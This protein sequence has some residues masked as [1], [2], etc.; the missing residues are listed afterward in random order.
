MEPTP[1]SEVEAGE[2]QPETTGAEAPKERD[3]FGR[4]PK[5]RRD[6]SHRRAE[7]RTFALMW[8]VFLMLATLVM[9]ASLSASPSV[10]PEVY[11]PAARTL[12][13]TVMLGAALLW[14]MMRLSQLIPREHRVRSV[15][16]DLVV[17]LLPVQA[18]VWPHALGMLS[19]WPLHVVGGVALSIAAWS[20]VVA[21]VLA[22][23]YVTMAPDASAGVRLT[24]MGVLLL[25]VGGVP[26][27]LLL[28]GGYTLTE[29]APSLEPAR[30]RM[31]SPLTSI[32][33]I[34]R[35]R[36]WSGRSAQIGSG[37]WRPMIGVL[38]L[39]G[40]LLVVARGLAL[41]RGGRSA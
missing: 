14:P 21:G 31:L 32:V 19:G 17:V 11:R 20:C 6:W 15:L 18:L 8:T 26:L 25:L 5:G 34:T 13:M 23:A 41:A 28:T 33:E 30:G 16:K 39:G 22:V 1:E 3:L 7:P 2:G 38:G 24:W 36:A 37:H 29:A 10:T 35:D 40:L 4:E 9:F 27:W 12:L